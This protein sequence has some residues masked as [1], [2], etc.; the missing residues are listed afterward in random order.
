MGLA[1]SQAR[2]LSI[3]SRMADNELRSQLINNAKMRLT[4]DTSKVS[5]EYIAALNR[6]QLMFTNFDLEG[7]EVY[8]DLTFNSLTAYSSYN[9]QYGIANNNG[10]LLVSASDA[11]KFEA[12][13]GDLDKF[14][15]MYGLEKTTDYWDTLKTSDEFT[16]LVYN[17]DAEY[18]TDYDYRQKDY[19]KGLGYYDSFGVWQPLYRVGEGET[20][21]INNIVDELQ[22]IYEG[23]A[24]NG[25]E[26]YGYK[27]T[28][29][30]PEYGDYQTLENEYI[31]A[32]ESYNAAVTTSMREY[33]SGNLKLGSNEFKVNGKTFEEIYQEICSECSSGSANYT[34]LNYYYKILTGTGD[35]NNKGFAELI[36]LTSNFELNSSASAQ[37]QMLQDH[38]GN[39]NMN[40]DWLN[41]LQSYTN[42]LDKN[43]NANIFNYI[44]GDIYKYYVAYNDKGERVFSDEVQIKWLTKDKIY[45]TDSSQPRD[46]NGTTY[47]EC[48]K[49]TNGA[50]PYVQLDISDKTYYP[51]LTDKNGSIYYPGTLTEYNTKLDSGD[52]TEVEPLGKGFERTSQK[53]TA[54]MYAD[55]LKALYDTFRNNVMNN[56]SSNIFEK[57]D[58]KKDGNGVLKKWQEYIQA[59]K[60]LA[61]FIYGNG[62]G[63]SIVSE[64]VNDNDY[65]NI[66]MIDYLNDPRW[67]L[68][69]NANLSNDVK[70]GDG[71]KYDVDWDETYVDAKDENGNTKIDANGNTIKEYNWDHELDKLSKSHTNPFADS[72]ATTTVA[73]DGEPDEFIAKYIDRIV[74]GVITYKDGETYQANYQTVKD[75]FY[76]DCL[77]EHYG[78]PIY[79]WID[80]NNKGENGTAKADWYTNLFNRMKQGYKRLDEGLKNSQDWLQFAFESGLVHMEQVDSKSVWNP[81][82]Y[83]NC[84]KINESTVDLDITLAEAKYKR[85]MAKIQAKDKQYDIELKNIDTEHESLKQEAESIKKVIED[86]IKTNM[87]LFVQS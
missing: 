20:E 12:A 2:L 53:L 17:A 36:G 39:D 26:H 74:S 10:E 56:M 76:L 70:G 13:N 34:V 81:T 50:I 63:D 47:Y 58:N 40:K 38:Y 78:E 69:Q 28:L 86:N 73:E 60:N 30:S 11:Q 23:N 37:N 18:G 87:K 79:T 64:M 48:D 82:L 29:T 80:Q 43:E 83:S 51:A 57:Y 7:N 9:T 22:A 5:D 84:A 25:I 61:N 15:G 1:A 42:V 66:K 65:K 59:A 77:M 49:N 6:T 8:Q 67:V 35:L 16:S 54:K 3:T 55:E 72:Y 75:L 32:R 45:A 44:S 19:I 68:S 46:I 85:E 33:L 14:L 62:N 21:S 31:A 24:Y 27:Y 41:A 71:Y 4:A 52:Y